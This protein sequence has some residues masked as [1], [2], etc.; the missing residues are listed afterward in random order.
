M[1]VLWSA[2][3]L[4]SLTMVITSLTLNW[5][6]FADLIAGLLVG[7]VVLQLTA[8]VD[9]A[10]PQT[11]LDGGPRRLARMAVACRAGRWAAGR[12]PASRRPR[13]RRP[14]L[15]RCSRARM[16]DRV[17]R[18]GRSSSSSASAS[19]AC[20]C[21]R[22]PR[23]GRGAAR[24][25]GWSG[26]TRSGT[27]ASPAPAT[28]HTV[29][30]PDGRHLSDYAF[31]PLL[32][33]LERVVAAVSGLA[34]VDAGLVVTWL[35]TALRGLGAL[36]R[37]RARCTAPASVSLLA[38]LW[39]VVPVAIVTSMAY[40]EALFTALAA[41]ARAR[42]AAPALAARRAAGRAG[43][44]DPAGRGWRWSP[45]S[46]CPPWSRSCAV[47]TA[48]ALAGMLLAPLGFL[49]YLAWVGVRTGEPLG[50]FRVADGWGNG[51]DGGRAF[52]GWVVDHLDGD[53]GGRACCC[54]PGCWSCS[55]CS[56]WRSVTGS[57]CRCSCSARRCWRWR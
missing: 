10:V 27:P 35:A 53:G 16:P 34:Y 13:S 41:W 56:C 55:A 57:R 8:A 43:G 45:R 9:T 49:G 1:R 18:S 37:R 24:T 21:S 15:R 40:S 29:L 26:G 33:V 20:W 3:A 36:R 44:A 17:Q 6:W 19:S 52:G 4:L 31:F 7:G 22:S 25:R 2:V 54:S 46:P 5:H 47:G 30:H 14:L 32:P 23:P 38:V 51:F 39:S 28:G 48:R 11:V 42:D 50:Y 12:A